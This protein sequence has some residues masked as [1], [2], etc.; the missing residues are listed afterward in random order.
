MPKSRVSRG[1]CVVCAK[2]KHRLSFFVGSLGGGGAERTVTSL[3]NGFHR[4]GY[5][6]DVLL[7]DL[8]GPYLDDLDAGVRVVNLRSRRAILSLWALVKYFRKVRPYGM[9]SAQSYLN[10]VAIWARV[11]SR[12]P[13]RLLVREAVATSVDANS[14]NNLKSR[15]V[16]ILIRWFY[17]LADLIITPSRGVAEDLVECIGITDAKIVV[18]PNPV[19]IRKLLSRSIESESHPWLSGQEPVVLGVGRLTPQKDFQS[20]IRAFSKVRTRCRARLIICGEGEQRENLEKLAGELGVGDAVSFPGFVKNPFSYMR[21]STVFV[22][23]SRWEGLPNTLLEA[24]A[25]GTPVVSTD[26]PSGPRE[27]LDGGRFGKLVPVSDVDALADAIYL[28][29]QRRISA[30]SPELI[31]RQYGPD[32]IIQCYSKAFELTNDCLCV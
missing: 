29:L 2:L 9:L 19:D 30:P 3:A 17:P 28:G 21:Q 25:I 20:L 1:L 23:S 32:K 14:S 11:L 18:I 16:P 22:L 15:L 6:V 10:V 4:R 31:K 5:L 12:V 8:Q 27:I 13:V 24:L 26:C 7:F